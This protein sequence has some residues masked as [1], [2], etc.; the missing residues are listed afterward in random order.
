MGLA[1][2]EEQVQRDLVENGLIGVL[3]GEACRIE[4]I[5]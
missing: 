4:E 1:K 5:T 2:I 3:I